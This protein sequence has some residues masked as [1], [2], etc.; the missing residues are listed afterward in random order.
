MTLIAWLLDLPTRRTWK[1]DTTTAI[2]SETGIASR[3]KDI[4][5]QQAASLYDCLQSLWPKDRKNE[6]I[7]SIARRL[8]AP[9]ITLAQ[10]VCICRCS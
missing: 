6:V 2:Y 8:I 4:E 7:S 5:H 1:H 9:A 10:K 3:Y